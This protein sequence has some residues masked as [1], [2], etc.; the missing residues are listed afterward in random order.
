MQEPSES[1]LIQ[2]N[3]TAKQNLNTKS[4]R[5]DRIGV[6]AA[7]SARLDAATNSYATQ[8]ETRLSRIRQLEVYQ[9]AAGVPEVANHGQSD[10]AGIEEYTLSKGGMLEEPCAG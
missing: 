6:D 8:Q 7:V 4:S 10:T 1:D 5:S 9:G 3:A 2:S